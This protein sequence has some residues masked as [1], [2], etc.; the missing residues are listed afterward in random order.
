M[1]LLLIKLIN[2]DRCFI[3]MR[4]IFGTDGIRGKANV[5]PMTGELAFRLGQAAA[6]K[7]QNHHEKRI[8]VIIG[9]DTRQSGYIFE[10]ALTA[11]LCSMGVDVY[12]VGPMPTPAVAHLVRSFAADA[13]VVI[14]ASHNPADDNG[15][16]FFDSQ[17]FK[18]ADEIEHEIEAL[19]ENPPS[20]EHI[21]GT[22]VGK[23]YRIDDAGGRYIE[24][25]KGTINNRSLSGL[26]VVLDC[27][28]GAA[29]KVTPK[30]FAELGADVE[31]FGN[32]PDGVNINRDCGAL[33]PELI[34]SAVLA[35]GADVGIALDGDAD[36]IIMVDETGTELD[37]DHIMALC[38]LHMKKNGSLS[39][40][41]IVSTVMSNMGF[42]VAMREHGIKMLRAPVGDRYVIDEMRKG[43][44]NLGGEQSGHIILSDLNS[45]GDG[46]VTALQVLSILKEHKRPLSEVRSAFQSYPQVLENVKVKEKVPLEKLP[47]V[48]KEIA[49]AEK[50]LG[51]AGRVLVRYSGTENKCRVMLEGRDLDQIKGYTQNIVKAIKNSIGE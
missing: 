15:I 39:K 14:S 30:I 26:K 46:T 33:H 23:A 12:L 9:K 10:Y 38:A 18:L 42:E 28:N 47:T 5:Y 22:R 51:S 43:G 34:R 4:K 13:G 50:E 32:Q 3:P 6:V 37:G 36:R 40:D 41:T 29:Y 31:V 8:K 35:S 2:P 19:I 45:T 24:F 1:N 25:A 7:F 27:A 20:S 49:A 48:Q 21:N 17:G 16:K 44:Y 11:G